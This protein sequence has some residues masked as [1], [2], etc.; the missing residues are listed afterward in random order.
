[1]YKTYIRCIFFKL[2]V[3]IANRPRVGTVIGT[4]Y[5]RNLSIL[6]F[7]RIVKTSYLKL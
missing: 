3:L 1:M 2:K 7:T 4:W 5:G 6:N